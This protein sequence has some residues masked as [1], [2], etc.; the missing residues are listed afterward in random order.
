MATFTYSMIENPAAY[1]AAIERNILANARKTWRNNNERHE[2]IETAITAGRVVNDEGDVLGYSENFIGSMAHAFD[3][4]GKLT[5]A[6]T[7]AVLKGIDAKAARIAEWKSKVAAENAN[8][9]WVGEVGKRID[10]E[11]TCYHDIRVD[12]FY[13]TSFICLCKDADGNTVVYKGN[14]ALFPMK[15]ETKKVKATI[16]EHGVRDGVKQTIISRPKIEV[17]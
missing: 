13:G 8:S 9:N 7:A 3:R 2:E 10:M 6:Q 15:G 4:Y 11:L 12:S 1:Q 17:E 16:K 14:S 5:P